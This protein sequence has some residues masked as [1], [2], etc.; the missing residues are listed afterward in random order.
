MTHTAQP[1]AHDPRIA[2]CLAAC[3]GL[4][5]EQLEGMVAES[6]PGVLATAYTA[7]AN[8]WEAHAADLVGA[9][10]VESDIDGEDAAATLLGLSCE[11]EHVVAWGREQGVVS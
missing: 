7:C 8:I 11:L 4:S 2:A 3:E 10:Q 1:I 5:T 9:D 6:G